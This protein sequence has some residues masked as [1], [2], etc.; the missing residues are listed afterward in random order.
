MR[1][2]VPSPESKRGSLTLFLAPPTLVRYSAGGPLGPADQIPMKK[3]LQYSALLG[4]LV[5]LL[6]SC[7]SIINQPEPG[8][9]RTWDHWNARSVPPRVDRFFL[10]YDADR[11]GAYTDK[12]LA[13]YAHVRKTCQRIFF[14]YNPDNPFQN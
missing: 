10:G 9:S 7:Q 4:L 12:L 13:D 6:P 1:P 14:S 8:P 2:L 5:A 3:L 11:D